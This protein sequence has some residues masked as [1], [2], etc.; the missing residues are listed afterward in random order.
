MA[1]LLFLPE[2]SSLIWTL[3]GNLDARKT[4]V[5]T[6]QDSNPLSRSTLFIL[7]IPKCCAVLLGRKKVTA[8]EGPVRD[9][10]AKEGPLAMSKWQMRV[11][12]LP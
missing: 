2:I 10:V 9:I 4:L 11:L 8:K 6:L 12:Q 7:N 1:I 5:L 3:T